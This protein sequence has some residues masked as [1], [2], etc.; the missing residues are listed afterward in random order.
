MAEEESRVAS[1]HAKRGVVLKALTLG[2]GPIDDS[3]QDSNALSAA[4]ETDKAFNATGALEPPYAPTALAFMYEHSP[5]LRSCID[6]YVTNIDAF[7][8]RLEPVIDL[9]SDTANARIAEV[10]IAE[11]ASIPGAKEAGVSP[12]PSEDEV[13]V[14]REIIAQEMVAEKAR[15]EA[16]FDF[17]VE[18]TSF[19]AWR[20]RLRQDL[21]V[22][23]NA[24]AE[25][26]RDDTRTVAEFGY[27]PSWTVRLM[28]QD[29]GRTQYESIRREGPLDYVKQ[30]KR[31]YFRRFVQI[32]ESRTVYFKEY[33]DPRP[34]GART[35]VFYASDDELQKAVRDGADVAATEIMHFKLPSPASPYGVPR[36][37][38]ALL[39]ILGSRAAEE[40][41]YDYFDNKAVPP[42]ALIIANGSLG[43]GVL[44]RINAHMQEL[45][46]KKNYHKVLLI[47]AE[48]DGG[49]F[50]SNGERTTV[51][52]QPLTEAQQ[53]DGLFLEYDQANIDKVGM[54][55]RMPRLLRGDVRD[56]N[57]AT[58]EAAI[59]FAEQQVFGPE[60]EE[61][62]FFINRK[63]MTELDAKHW[64][65]RSNA[66]SVRNP[67]ALTTMISTLVMAGV[68]TPSEARQ[69]AGGVF[70]LELA[71]IDAAWTKQPIQLTLA[72]IPVQAAAPST[73]SG[74]GDTVDASYQAGALGA[75]LALTPTAFGAVV[76][77][78][79]ARAAQGL[80]PLL[81]PDGSEHPDGRL[82]VTE[83]QNKQQREQFSRFPFGGAQGGI[84]GIGAVGVGIPGLP[85]LKQLPVA[86]VSADTAA[87]QLMAIR[88][89]LEAMEAFDGA[90]EWMAAHREQ[91]GE[92]SPE[93]LGN[94]FGS[95]RRRK[96][97]TK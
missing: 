31:K 16:F 44:E 83:Y 20:K 12:R 14:R 28:P 9:D 13:L 43:K 92:L 61:F 58:A 74:E 48:S 18:D 88:K 81:L 34:M 72:G 76:T 35:G 25:V 40:V 70:G 91:L 85:P 52:F 21:E 29:A 80:G 42:L 56:F 67:E 77:V 8:H 45:K 47:E 4:S 23:G 1:D 36:W 7:G 62:D 54:V 95:R 66:P 59:E 26:M 49:P 6:A 2:G 93:V 10:I 86:S 39:S 37:I 3:V 73:Y 75:S 71:Q 57:R 32:V 64:Q 19:V 27:L 17:A 5:A 65:F 11:R 68:L 30:R 33:G 60:R 89:S 63:V 79:E 51:K 94:I 96:G 53:K 50:D 24:Y 55:F 15:V 38:S 69:L 41:N 90:R 78:N 82:T 46:G 87:N 22:T 97:Q 84:P